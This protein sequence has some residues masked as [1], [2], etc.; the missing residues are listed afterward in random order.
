[1]ASKNFQKKKIQDTEDS[2][3]GNY[4][5][6]VG[7]GGSPKPKNP[8]QR[9]P[10]VNSNYRSSNNDTM[11]PRTNDG[12]FTYKSVNGKSI[13]P[14]Y[15]PSRGKTVNPLLTGGENGVMIEDVEEQF[16]SQSGAY[17]NK[18]KDKWYQKGSEMVLGNVGKDWHTRVAGEA[19]WNV[20][21]RRYDSVKGEFESESHVFD[22][23]KKGAPSNAAKAAKQKAE[24][25]GEE[26]AVIDPNTGGMRLKPGVAIKPPSSQPQPGA[27]AGNTPVVPTGGNGIQPGSTVSASDIMNA[28]Y[29]PKY[30]DD[31]ISQARNILKE[32]GL[33]DSELADFDNLSPKEKDAY[34]DEHFNEVDEEETATT[35]ENVDAEDKVTTDNTPSN[36]SSKK[37]KNKKEDSETIKKIKNMGFTGDDEDK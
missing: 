10:G 5:E 35:E 7:G 2:N 4:E 36:P 11:Q 18:Y 20:A 6:G 31:D 29:T 21:K 12:K 30:S 1:M 25:T 8:T 15:G 23:T 32:G 13:D 28:D 34:I 16:A 24:A 19:V 27:N 14:K 33:S 9:A 37:D 17:W 22:E 3:F 26:Q